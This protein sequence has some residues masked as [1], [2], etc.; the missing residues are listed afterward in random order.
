MLDSESNVY[1]N[2][3]L[4][5]V[6]TSPPVRPHVNFR[7]NSRQKCGHSSNYG[8]DQAVL[9]IRIYSHIVPQ[10]LS[11]STGRYSNYFIQQWC[12]P[13]TLTR[14]GLWWYQYSLQVWSTSCPRV[15]GGYWPNS[16]M[17]LFIR[18][19]FAIKLR[20]D[21]I[22]NLSI[23]QTTSAARCYVGQNFADIF[24]GVL[25]RSQRKYAV[26]PDLPPWSG[27]AGPRGK[28]DWWWH[29]PT[30]WPRETRH[31]PGSA[32]CKHWQTVLDTPLILFL[33][34]LLQNDLF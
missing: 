2:L 28:G 27:L 13:H 17:T 14:G 9:S 11:S 1:G 33:L 32:H 19:S 21:I 5:L 18:M 26:W 16:I 8:G 31:Y 24:S 3:V 10:F 29:G 34:L 7:F 25:L 4:V 20:R 6:L 15:T 30:P 23:S 12:C 22:T